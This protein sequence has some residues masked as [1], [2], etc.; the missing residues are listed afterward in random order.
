MTS[1]PTQSSVHIYSTKNSLIA[2]WFCCFKMGST[3]LILWLQWLYAHKNSQLKEEN[4]MY[5]QNVYNLFSILTSYSKMF[6]SGSSTTSC[7]II[8]FNYIFKQ[9]GIIYLLSNIL[10]SWSRFHQRLS[11]S[12]WETYDT[13]TSL[14]INSYFFVH[15]RNLIPNILPIKTDTFKK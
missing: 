1:N 9:L 6:E 10:L 2:C 11:F 7:F 13:I 4:V 12:G 3:H 14:T 5:D 8:D 15:Q